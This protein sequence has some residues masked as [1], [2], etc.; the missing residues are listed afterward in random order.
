MKFKIVKDCDDMQDC[1]H[2]TNGNLINPK[3]GTWSRKVEKAVVFI[4]K[5]KRHFVCLECLL[6]Q[7]S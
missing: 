7:K 5:E 4:G 6:E 3:T 2:S 1:P